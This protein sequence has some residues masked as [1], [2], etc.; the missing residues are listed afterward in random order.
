[1]RRQSDRETDRERASIECATRWRPDPSQAA[2]TSSFAQHFAALQRGLFFRAIHRAGRA[3]P[4]RVFFN[5]EAREA[6]RRRIAAAQLRTWSDVAS[7]I[8]SLIAERRP[9]SDAITCEAKAIDDA[10]SI[11]RASL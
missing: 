3:R 1:M 7:D 8:Q 5:P 11:R 10:H 4:L 2:K 6:Y 9:L